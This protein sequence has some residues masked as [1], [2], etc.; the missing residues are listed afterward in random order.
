MK[1]SACRVSY[2][3]VRKTTVLDHVS[4]Y[5]LLGNWVVQGNFGI[6]G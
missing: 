4:H 5:F 3:V 1:V 2:P 6:S